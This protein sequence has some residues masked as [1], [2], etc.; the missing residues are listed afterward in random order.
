MQLGCAGY[1]KWFSGG[2]IAQIGSL[3]NGFLKLLKECTVIRKALCAGL[4]VHMEGNSGI[5]MFLYDNN[6]LILRS[7]VAYYEHVTLHFKEDVKTV[8][9]LTTGRTYEVKDHELTL[10]L[11]SCVNYVLSYM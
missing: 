5:Q 7:D 3:V 4:P 9:E 10:Q 2:I 6:K 8:K 11:S 1:R